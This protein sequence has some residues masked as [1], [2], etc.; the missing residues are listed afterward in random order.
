MS[1]KQVGMV[2]GITVVL[3]LVLAWVIEQ[4]QVRR[5]MGEFEKW[6]EGRFSGNADAS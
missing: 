6:Y 2:I 4:A 5:F 3:A 1:N